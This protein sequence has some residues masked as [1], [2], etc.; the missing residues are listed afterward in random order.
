MGAHPLAPDNILHN[1][2]VVNHG[3]P[4][5]LEGGFP[6]FAGGL[7]QGLSA[8]PTDLLPEFLVAT[9]SLARTRSVY[10]AAAE[11]GISADV[12]DVTETLGSVG[13]I[14]EQGIALRFTPLGMPRIQAMGEMLASAPQTVR[15]EA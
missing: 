6:S 10:H 14:I 11:R 3:R 9:P 15:A 5:Q 7:R 2:H 13:R 1:D 12:D 4:L 8:P